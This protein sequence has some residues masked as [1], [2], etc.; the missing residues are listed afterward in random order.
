MQI[1]IKYDIS[2]FSFFEIEPGNIILNSDENFFS[3]N[4]S[5]DGIISTLFCDH[6][7]DEYIKQDGV[8]ANIKFKIN[9]DATK[10]RCFV[11]IIN[12][13]CCIADVSFN[14][15][16]FYT[17]DGI[18]G[19][20]TPKDITTTNIQSR[21]LVQ[22]T[23]SRVNLNNA[24]QLVIGDVNGDF[25]VNS[26]DYS[27]L[28]NY[29]LGY[30]SN[31]PVDEDYY[32]ADV[33]GD[34]SINSTDKALM[35]RVIL[36]LLTEFPKKTKLFVSTI[37]NVNSDFQRDEAA[38]YALKYAENSNTNAYMYI[39]NAD[40]TNFVSQCLGDEPEGGN[41]SQGGF[42]LYTSYS[43]WY[44]NNDIIPLGSS[45]TWR[46]A[47]NFRYHWGNVNGTGENRAYKMAIYYNATDVV[48]DWG[49]VMMRLKK[50]DVFQLAYPD[51]E[52]YHSMV[53]YGKYYNF[54][55]SINDAAYAQHSI[56][57]TEGS[58]Y[59]KVNS[60]ANVGSQNIIIFYSIKEVF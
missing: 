7:G 2:N 45:N 16:S 60:W 52:T 14:Q 39:P 27:I 48:N 18:I 12:S 42:P 9:N 4:N 24:N 41:A 47:H 5:T 28:N 40:C 54:G 8:F 11:Q 37:N 59:A 19:I 58:L 15:V 38:A 23:A 43:S 1:K 20:S 44:Y 3:A 50:G 57:K 6:S 49:N 10:G 25:S 36:G 56:D 51:G 22:P 26:T 34:G 33:N 13:D 21:T 55:L 30:L 17:N 31:L 53:I 46:A 29:L 32:A 35:R